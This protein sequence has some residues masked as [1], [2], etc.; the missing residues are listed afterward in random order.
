[1]FPTQKQ[2][3]V[4]GNGFETK[5]RGSREAEKNLGKKVIVETRDRGMKHLLGLGS[6]MHHFL[7]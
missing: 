5:D 7:E 4:F 1:M 2:T 3:P 6:G